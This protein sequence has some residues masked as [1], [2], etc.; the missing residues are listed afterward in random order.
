MEY[1]LRKRFLSSQWSLR[2][3]A[4]GLALSAIL[5]SAGA[6]AHAQTSAATG[7]AASN[8]AAVTLHLTPEQEK[9]IGASGNM[10]G[11]DMAPETTPAVVDAAVK[12]IPV[13]MAV[14]PV[15]PTWQSI[16]QHYE[17]P[18]WFK[19]A[20]L[21]IFMHFGIFSVPA[22]G[23]E[24]YEK[25]M[26]AGGPDK[27]LEQMGDH[28]SF[29]A[30]HTAHFGPPDQF[31][32]K[33]FIP[34]FKA[35]H[36]NA[37][38]WAALF[39]EAGARYVVPGAQ[40]HENFAMWNS[41]VTPFNAVKMGPHQDI[42]GQLAVAIRKQGMKLGLANHGIENFQF[43]NPPKAMADKMKAEKADLYDPKWANFY[44]VADR[45]DTALEKF[46]VN[47]YERNVE[48]I[49]KYHPD[50]MYFDNGI[51]QRYLDP[52]KLSVAAYYYN[53]ASGW[54][55]QVTF[56]TKKAAFAPS[57]TNLETIGSVLDFEGSDPGGIRTGSWEEDRP[58]GTSWG[59]ITGMKLNSTATVLGWLVDVVSKNGNLLL[60]VSPMA[61]G[62]IPADQQ[63]TL[64]AIGSW[65]HANGEA[66]YDTHAW[67]R[68]HDSGKQDVY[69]TV[70]DQSL[71]AIVMA[72]APTTDVLIESLGR[73]KAPAGSVQTVT[74]VSSGARLPFQQLA[75]GLHVKL[76]AGF[77]PEQNDFAIKI[78][79]LRMN[80][81]TFT[82]SG[83]PLPGNGVKQNEAGN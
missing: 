52:L 7:V 82:K 75:D 38:A 3:I 50:L 34:M 78:T 26:Y 69:F 53:R 42:I 72:K 48:L 33:D 37:D 18:D 41:Q 64:R 32:Y 5:G 40:H 12:Q 56:T 39:K 1:P 10:Q 30:W 24:W 19:G 31:G 45:S 15:Q 9:A 22:H 79:G 36:F 57:G 55:K 8:A 47:W 70:K 54:G 14:G 46:L 59:Y 2:P 44:N 66:I 17:V 13:K 83:N 29:V 11:Y 35:Q 6:A 25:F 62:T 81:S 43:I 71:Y 60:N 27:T 28:E 80:G 21:G 73:G 4:S 77:A 61:D 20:K 23:S 49:N 51:D 63:N 16:Q 76:P 68:F 67:T 74:L 58:I 65:L